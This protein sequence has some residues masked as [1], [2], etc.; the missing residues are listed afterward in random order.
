MSDDP[1][2]LIQLEP[3]QEAGSAGCGPAPRCSSPPGP[4][5]AD[6]HRRCIALEDERRRLASEIAEL[7]PG[8]TPECRRLVEREWTVIREIGKILEQM[9]TTPARTIDDVAALVDLAL[10][11]EFDASSPDLL[12][13]DRPWTLGL[14]RALRNLAP[15]VEISWLRRQSTHAVDVAAEIFS[16][17][18]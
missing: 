8:E 4:A 14:I 12:L 17:E 2:H 18:D 3:L 1:H 6:L 11:I 16:G 10:D 9:Q 7:R 13:Q 15:K 5:V